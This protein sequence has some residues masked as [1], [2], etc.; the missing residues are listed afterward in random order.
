MVDGLNVVLESRIRD[1]TE[2]TRLVDL[3]WVIWYTER[4]VEIVQLGN[5]E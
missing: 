5:Y 1:A 2:E 3:H 4:P